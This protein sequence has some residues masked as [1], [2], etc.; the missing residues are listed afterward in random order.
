MAQCASGVAVGTSVHRGRTFRVHSFSSGL[1]DS[2]IMC[3]RFVRNQGLSRLQLTLIDFPQPEPSVLPVR[4]ITRV[5]SSSQAR[6]DRAVR[7]L[8]PQTRRSASR[9]VAALRLPLTMGGKLGQ[10][11]NIACEK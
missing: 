1:D 2:R 3:N 11:L 4:R 9:V 8:A 6:A 5:A 10:A 7:R